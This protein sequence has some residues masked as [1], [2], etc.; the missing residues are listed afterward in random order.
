M[1]L[2]P[3]FKATLKFMGPLPGWRSALYECNSL[4]TPAFRTVK[5]GVFIWQKGLISDPQSSNMLALT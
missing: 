3:I 2:W 4:V 5:D 1:S